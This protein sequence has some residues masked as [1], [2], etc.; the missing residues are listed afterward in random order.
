LTILV[1]GGAG[2]VGSHVSAELL[3]SG[4]DVIIADNFS[5]SARGVPRAVGRAAGQDAECRELDLTDLGAVEKLFAGDHIDGVI[6]CAGFKAAG[7]SVT[8]P[9]AYYRNNIVS[10]LN[11]LDVMRA[12]KVRRL[13]FSS[14]ATVYG[15]PK[16]LPLTETMAAW[17][18][19]N[20]YGTTKLVIERLIE[21]AATADMSLS[22]VLL[23]YFNP[24]GAH[25][26]GFIGESPNGVPNNLMPYITQVALGRLDRLSVYG[27]DYPTRDGSCIRDYIHVTDLARGHVAALAYCMERTG[28]EAINLGRGQGYSV[29]EMLSAFE[30]VNG[31]RI[32]YVV[33]DRRA[34]DVAELCADVE[35]AYR[36]L[37][38]R[39]EQSVDDM[40][41]DAWNFAKAAAAQ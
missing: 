22:A 33:T 29:F 34:G 15:D 41:R 8:K 3:S 27:N 31:V 35:K 40:C 32:P 9:T 18:C 10:T 17:P 12:R 19:A 23:R 25:R 38:W 20:P 5:N 16:K 6:H 24:V 26:S 30:R 7:E 37:G 4:Y 13:I 1:T 21:D 14:S 39:A 36:L 11:L 2:Y 28:V